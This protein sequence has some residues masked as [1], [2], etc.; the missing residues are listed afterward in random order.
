MSFR[1]TLI[2]LL[3]A[4]GAAGRAAENWPSFQNGGNTSIEAQR[5]P[6]KWTPTEGVAWRVRL[7]GYGQSVPI[8]WGDRVYVTAVEGESKETNVVLA[9]DGETGK[10]LWTKTFPATVQ[11][12]NSYMVSRAAPTPLADEEGL[13]A[14]FESGDLHALS[15]DGQP[16]WRR[17]FFDNGDR[18]FQNGHGYGASPTQTEDA[19]IVLVDHRGPS[20]LTAIAKR[21]GRPLWKTGRSPRSS[22]TSPQAARV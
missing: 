7:P 2:G 17:S 13:Y 8:V 11:T 12:R 16:Q 6:L 3:L 5:L 10:P 9:I 22:W 20:Y 18:A 21:T 15:H 4:S 14:L 19:V 1:F